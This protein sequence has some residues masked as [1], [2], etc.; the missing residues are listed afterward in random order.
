MAKPPTGGASCMKAGEVELSGDQVFCLSHAVLFLLHTQSDQ[1]GNTV[2]TA[3]K[4]NPNILL[5]CDSETYFKIKS[6]S[7]KIIS[8]I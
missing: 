5:H 8:E 6:I 2:C 7:V 3:E 4:N 1:K